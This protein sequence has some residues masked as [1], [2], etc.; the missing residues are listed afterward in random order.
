[1]TT[2][3]QGGDAGSS[4]SCTAGGDPAGFVVLTGEVQI[5]LVEKAVS[6]STPHIQDFSLHRDW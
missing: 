2:E 3:L 4:M 1:V 6:E 5:I